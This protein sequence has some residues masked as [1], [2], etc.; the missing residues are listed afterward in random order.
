MTY[1]GTR[2][3]LNTGARQ[4]E[5]HL[6]DFSGN[7]Y[8]QLLQTEFIL[9]LRPDS[10]FPSVDDLIAQLKLDAIHTREALG[11]IPAR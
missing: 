11:A 7:L 5:T 1:I 3:A 10:N 4:I 8:G 2:P 6:L 9:R